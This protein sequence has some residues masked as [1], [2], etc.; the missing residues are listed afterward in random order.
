MKKLTIKR[1]KRR[2]TWLSDRFYKVVIPIYLSVIL[3]MAAAILLVLQFAKPSNTVA[4]IMFACFFAVMLLLPLLFLFFGLPR[5]KTHQAMLELEKHYDF[6][7]YEVGDEAT[8]ESVVPS[9]VFYYRADPFDKDEK[10]T[11]YGKDEAEKLASTLAGRRIGWA[12]NEKINLPFFFHDRTADERYTVYEIEKKVTGDTL[13]LS[14]A[15]YCKLTFT[16]SGIVVGQSTFKY[17][18]VRAFCSLW[19]DNTAQAR[20]VVEA[21]EITATFAVGTKIYAALKKFGVQVENNELLEY[22]MQDPRKAFRA[23]AS[24]LSLKQQANYTLK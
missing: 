10:T 2:R 6:S 20:I 3:I 19:Y 21:D 7:P 8:F 9:A 11:R 14:V 15:Q 23:V 4:Y 24:T 18:N 16:Q 13:E 22:I 5:M 17:D 1:G 12:E